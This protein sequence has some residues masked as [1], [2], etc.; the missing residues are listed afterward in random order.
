M[1]QLASRDMPTKT[2]ESFSPLQRYVKR[3]DAQAIL[4][5]GHDR[6]YKLLGAGKLTAIKDGSNTLISVE[7]IHA[8]QASLPAAT[9][10]PPTAEPL[11]EPGQRRRG[12]RRV[13]KGGA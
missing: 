1:P 3:V 13:L 2:L 11:P 9:F 7:S 10:K 8:Y 4:C 5:M 6:L 12:R